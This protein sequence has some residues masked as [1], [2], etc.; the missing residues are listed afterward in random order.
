MFIMK[1]TTNFRQLSN[2]WVVYQIHDNPSLE[3]VFVGIEKVKNFGKFAD[4]LSNPLMEKY[5]ENDLQTFNISIFATCNSRVEALQKQSDALFEADYPEAN[6]LSKAARSMQ[7]KCINDGKTYN[8][9]EECCA[10]YGISQSALSKHLRNL[11]GHKTVG[12][13][14]YKNVKK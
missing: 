11:P 1:A 2:G 9:Q 14:I 8:T 3:I 4:F 10:A 12:G 7:I 13:K 5:R 6:L